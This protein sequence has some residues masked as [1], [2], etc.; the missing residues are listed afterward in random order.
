MGQ[1]VNTKFGLVSRTGKIVKTF[2]YIIY[3]TN[4]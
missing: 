3:R 1:M 2:C 4:K